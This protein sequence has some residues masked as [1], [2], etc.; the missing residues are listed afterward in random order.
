MT[1]RDAVDPDTLKV[2]ELVRDGGR[3]WRVGLVNPSRARLD[4]VSGVATVSPVSGRTFESF[5][6]S[7][8]VAPAA[9]VEKVDEATLTLAERARVITLEERELEAE[10]AEVAQ[11]P[12]GK[13]SLKEQNE[14]RR[15]KLA[16]K[17]EAV[18]KEKAEKVASGETVATRT[19]KEP[20]ACKC[21]CGGTTTGYFVPGHD[22]RFKSWL[23]QI[24]RGQKKPEE[25]LTEAV[26]QSYTWKKTADGKGLMPTTTYKGQPHTGYD[27]K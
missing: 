27:T 6:G 26:R 1:K 18:K 8:N 17:K 21:G 12:V 7:V 13:K 23:L 19:P 4:P 5:G 20:K 2:G 3:I 11:M 24:E 10:M 22:A 14:E 25:L 16:E 15:A 9:M